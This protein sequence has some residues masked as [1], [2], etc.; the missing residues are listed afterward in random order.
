[1]KELD[2]QLQKLH[3]FAVAL[4][5]QRQGLRVSDI[6]IEELLQN[7]LSLAAT[8]NQLKQEQSLWNVL[9]HKFRLTRW[10]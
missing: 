8:Y 9:L 3:I 6:R 4:V 10:L 1:M 7:G 5:A 2:I